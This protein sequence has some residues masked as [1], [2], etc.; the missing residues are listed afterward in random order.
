MDHV[1]ARLEA[2]EQ[3]TRSVER[4]LRWWRSL[5]GVLVGLGLGLWA[6]PAVT[7]GDAQ[8]TL[9]R[10][11]AALETLLTPFSRQGSEII[12]TGANLR[13]VNGLGSTDCTD[14]QGEPIPQC[15]NG[16]G[17]VIVG[18]NEPRDTPEGGE[19]RNVR[20][21][22]HNIV[23]GQQHNFSRIGGLVVGVW[24]EISG[25]FAAVSG[26]RFNTASGVA[27]T[28][29]GGTINTAS[30][31]F[32]GVSGGT[33]NTASGPESVVSGGTINTAS[34]FAAAVSGGC[35][36]AASGVLG[37]VSGGTHNTASGVAAVVGGGNNNTASH[38]LSSV[39]GGRHRTAAGEFDWVAGPLFADE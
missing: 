25:D 11:V 17:N 37:A 2:L 8:Q 20:T 10:R 27:A 26:G 32:A 6:L 28:V 29:S 19:E 5:A 36:N 30:G 38:E 35:C 4:Q 13:V 12:M 23:V 31:A 15:P 21:G 7:A 39:S 33:L 14:A 16:L 24:N 1:Q 22:S 3:H 9:E 34:G 18:Y